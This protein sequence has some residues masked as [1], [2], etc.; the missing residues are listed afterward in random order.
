MRL[1]VTA[2]GKELDSE[3]DA[4]FGRCSY[5][6]LIDPETMEFEAIQNSSKS[7]R[8]GAGVQAAET[9]SSNGVDALAT[10]N[11][12][13]NAF[14]ALSS[15]GIKVFTGAS[16]TIK[17]TVEDYENGKLQQANEPTTSGGQGK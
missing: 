12:G 9:L 14:N 4:R 5:F 17:E 11:V 15:A 16:G 7:A 6:L 3:A 10:G 8:G 2:K 13:P 1:A